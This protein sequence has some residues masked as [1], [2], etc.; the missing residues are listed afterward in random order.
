ME[1][2]WQPA[3][4]PG[5]GK[6]VVE[7]IWSSLRD[8]ERRRPDRALRSDG[9]PLVHEPNRSAQLPER[10]VLSVHRRLSDWRSHRI[11]V[12]LFL[13]GER[14]QGERLPEVRRVAGRLLH[15]DE[16]VQRKF[17][18]V[19]RRWRSCIRTKQDDRRFTGTNG[20]LRPVFGEPESIRHASIRHGR[21]HAAPDGRAELLHDDGGRFVRLHSRPA[22]ALEI[23][24]GLDQYSGFEFHGT[25]CPEHGVFR[26]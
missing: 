17:S 19:R 9:G 16:P 15:V 23:S 10:P 21:A 20:L 8:D 11:V 4:R 2:E 24:C 6:Y 22:S 7:R 5:E 26:F 14:R 13:P 3:L 25:D 12:P 18:L 1:Q